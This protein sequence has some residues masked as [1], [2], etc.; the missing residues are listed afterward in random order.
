MEYRKGINTQLEFLMM[1]SLLLNKNV[2]KQK[3]NW[4]KLKAFMKISTQIRIIST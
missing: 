2:A 4:H 3:D 1:C